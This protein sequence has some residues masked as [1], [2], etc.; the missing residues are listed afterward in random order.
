[1]SS[2][3]L[4]KTEGSDAYQRTQGR[5]VYYR[6]EMPMAG[7]VI[8]HNW[9]SL[10]GYSTIFVERLISESHP[11][12]GI[13]TDDVARFNEGDFLSPDFHHF[14]NHLKLFIHLSPFY[15]V[16]NSILFTQKLF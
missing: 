11:E 5:A 4:Y 1:M 2:F 8:I 10:L 3:Y 13:I 7:D 6:L 15:S 16:E 14:L 9:N 12:S